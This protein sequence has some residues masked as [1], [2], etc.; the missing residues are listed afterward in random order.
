MVMRVNAE[1]GGEELAK[2]FDVSSYPT[3][4]FA[5][6]DGE[7]VE[8]IRGYLPPD[9][10]LAEVRRVR[11]GD[12]FAACLA[13]LEEQ[14]GDLETLTRAVDGLLQRSD[15]EGALTRLEAFRL[16]AP[17]TSTA[18]CSVLLFR[19]RAALQD[20]LYEHAAQ[21]YDTGWKHAMEVPDC[22]VGVQLR[23]ALEQ[24]L[25][26]L[27]AA[28][29]RRMLREARRQDGGA[30]LSEVDPGSLHGEDILT[31]AR[32]AAAS[33]IYERATELFERW[34]DS[35]GAEAP[36]EALNEVAWELYLMRQALD[37]G[38]KIARAALAADDSPDI[39][40]TLARLLYVTGAV[41][42]AIAVETRAAEQAEGKAADAFRDVAERMKTGLPLDDQPEFESYPE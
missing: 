9:A 3:L 4:V 38:V 28:E 30:L 6:A 29:Q 18:A 35:E 31:A 24:G 2:R 23:A 39:A 34:V 37:R 12:T 8:R 21:L 16:A 14:P 27:D 42:E 19:A 13:R 22:G 7:E 40:D 1:R 5:N 11:A 10:F 26:E 17:E 20:R 33:G 15:P 32:F 36:P 41:D 25:T